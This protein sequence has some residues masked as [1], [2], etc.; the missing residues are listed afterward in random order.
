MDTIVSSGAAGRDSEDALKVL[1]RV[2]DAFDN[3]G[4]LHKMDKEVLFVVNVVK[5]RHL[6]TVGPC[7]F[8][9]CPCLLNDDVQSLSSEE[10]V[11]QDVTCGSY[12]SSLD[13]SYDEDVEVVELGDASV[14]E[15]ASSYPYASRRYQ[16][17]ERVCR[18]VRT[19]FLR[20][21]RRG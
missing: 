2:A 20:R 8:H 16:S 11:C 3:P 4:S 13:T 10:S 17:P 14:W 5:S 6:L 12:D 21:D 15:H 18:Q 1:G 7:F 19:S 9:S